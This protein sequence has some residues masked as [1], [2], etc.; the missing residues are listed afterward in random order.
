MVR[1]MVYYILKGA[2]GYIDKKIL[3]DPFSYDKSAFYKAGF[4]SRAA[5][6]SE[7]RLLR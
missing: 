1:R 6:F 5:F 3:Q 2:Q 7:C 4:T